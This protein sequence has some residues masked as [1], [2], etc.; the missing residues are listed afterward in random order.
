MFN[1]KSFEDA[2][3]QIPAQPRNSSMTQEFNLSKWVF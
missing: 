1:S 3:I 2:T